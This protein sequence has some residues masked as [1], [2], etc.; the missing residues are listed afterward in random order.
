M[1]QD[2]P[3]KGELKTATKTFSKLERFFFWVFL[4]LFIGTT[5]YVLW[6]INE[7]FMVIKP[8]KGGELIEG[9]SD[10]PRFIN[11][12]LATGEADRDLSA[13]VYSG[14]LRPTENGNYI[15]DLSEKYEISTDGLEYTFTIKK[16]AIWQDGEP[17]TSDDIEFTIQ[18]ARDPVLR[19]PKRAIWEGVTVTKISDKEIKFTLKQPFQ[20]FLENAT[21][22]I[23]PK[24]KWKNVDSDKFVHN[25]LNISKPIGTG[26]Y[27]F[28]KISKDISSG[29][30]NYIELVP[31]KD[32]V[33]G[34]PKISKIT[35][36]FYSNQENLYTAYKNGEIN[37]M[38]AVSPKIIEEIQSNSNQMVES[39]LPRILAVFYNQNQ[40]KV[41]A[42]K[43]VRLALDT[44]INRQNIIDKI[45]LGYGTETTGPIPPGAI[46]L[47]KINTNEANSTS[48]ENT[49]EAKQILAK[50]GWKLNEKT[51]LLEKKISSKEK[52]TLEVGLTTIDF[53]E[54][55]A[56]AEIIKSDWEKIGVKV[57]LQIFEKGDLDRNVIEPRKYDA[58]F[59]GEIVG[60]DLDLFSFWHSSQRKNPGVNI[61]MYANAKVDKILESLKAERDSAKKIKL[62]QEFQS[63]I[64]KDIP[65]S[66]VYSPHFLYIVPQEIKGV[67]IL[68]PITASDRF[69][70]VYDWYMKTEKVW[71]IF[72]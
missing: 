49:E 28:K 7:S 64:G 47:R 63:E 11:P 45:L 19:S 48:T 39:N 4:F 43:N 16:D 55:K 68:P 22:G 67:K 59:F 42:N 51:Q 38:N 61:A 9:I 14:L 32:Y 3:T 50:D 57:N 41:L 15:N 40:S 37:S 70:N 13:L 29:N 52:M 30:P 12:L 33:L 24:H 25:D 54:L 44:A 23:L 8:V 72:E 5:S 58:L 2:L 1:L 60:R 53:T 26:P 21:M 65:A 20:S 69:L 35:L 66:F 18:K 34:E 46:D 27:K 62:L 6:D 71:K 56:A 31:F 10:I 36:K 17:V